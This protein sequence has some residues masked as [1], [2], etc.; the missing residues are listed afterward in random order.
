M[1]LELTFE[2]QNY[3]N[4][5]AG[6]N[7]LALPA[8][9]EKTKIFADILDRL[10]KELV[11]RLRDATPRGVTGLL[12]RSTR[13]VV[14]IEPVR[15]TVGTTYTLLILQDARPFPFDYSP[16]VVRGR[17]PNRRRP[18]SSALEGWVKLKWGMSGEAIIPASFKLARS[19]GIKGTKPS[20]YPKKVIEQSD[21]I[22]GQ[23]ALSLGQDLTVIL[24]E[25]GQ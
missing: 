23:T 22:I 19:I 8:S 25:F 10:G 1:P 14:L 18:P 21:D 24:T 17:Q 3:G 7:A 15:D 6:L 2:A 9:K 5:Q 12:A 11:S 20:P 4:I 16:I 13:H